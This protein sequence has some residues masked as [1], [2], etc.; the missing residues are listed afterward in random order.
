MA[1]KIVDHLL[2]GSVKVEV[3]FQLD[4]HR[5]RMPIFRC[6]GKFDLP[7]CGHSAFSQT[8]RKARDGA[9]VG[10]LAAGSKHGPQ[11]NRSS[12]LILS[13]LFRVLRFGLGENMTSFEEMG[14]LSREAKTDAD[15]L[16]RVFLGTLCEFL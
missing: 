16:G 13:C 4:V 8:K 5:N 12:Y 3:V 9:D 6:R 10:Y 7:C 1:R 2:T 11:N 15:R 14:A